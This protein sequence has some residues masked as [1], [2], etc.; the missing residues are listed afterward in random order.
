MLIVSRVLLLGSAGRSLCR[1]NFSFLRA[2]Y[3]LRRGKR[4]LLYMENTL[5]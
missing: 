2:S 5:L 4:V 3:G 1:Q